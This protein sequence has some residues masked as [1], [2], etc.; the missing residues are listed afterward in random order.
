MRVYYT[1]V[2]WMSGWRE[3]GGR[4]V[5]TNEIWRNWLWKNLLQKQFLEPDKWVT[6]MRSSPL[7]KTANKSLHDPLLPQFQI[8]SSGQVRKCSTCSS[9][10]VHVHVQVSPLPCFLFSFCPV[11]F[12]FHYFIVSLERRAARIFLNCCFKLY[13]LWVTLYDSKIC[14]HW[15]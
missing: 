15:L 6:S 14:G 2:I 8:F 13:L 7:K 5:I 1:W 3:T 9:E 11:L 12:S 10:P 4:E